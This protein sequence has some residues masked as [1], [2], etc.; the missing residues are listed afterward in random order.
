MKDAYPCRWING[1]NELVLLWID[2]DGKDDHFAIGKNGAV[3][4]YRS[5]EA[6]LDDRPTFVGVTAHDDNVAILD[7]GHF[8]RAFANIR[9][10]RAS[11]TSTCNILLDSWNAFED[12]GRSL[13]VELS[14]LLC[15][16]VSLKSTYQKLLYGCNLPSITPENKS[17][18]PIWRADEIA[19]FKAAIRQLWSILLRSVPML[20]VLAPT[21]AAQTVGS[22]DRSRLN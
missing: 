7:I 15:F 16:D 1:D 21:S 12:M 18:S 2:G 6:L 19:R 4:I 22:R 11:S 10:G 17:Y 14:E 8:W 5:V 9:A 3:C 13:H 20:E